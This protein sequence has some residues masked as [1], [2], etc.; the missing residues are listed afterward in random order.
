MYKFDIGEIL[1]QIITKVKCIVIPLTIVRD[2]V[3]NK[4]LT[5]YAGPNHGEKHDL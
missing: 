5:L 4:N 1:L 2:T 3:F